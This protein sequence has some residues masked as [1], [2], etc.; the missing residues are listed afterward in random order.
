MRNA[1]TTAALA[2]LTFGV[3]ATAQTR[4]PPTDP[5][6][7]PSLER[8]MTGAER[9]AVAQGVS[10]ADRQFILDAA[11]A[12]LAEVEMG[13]L[14]LK[15]GEASRVKDFGQ[16]LVDDHGKANGELATLAKTLSVDVPT[17]TDAEHQKHLDLLAQKKGAEFDRVFATHMVEGHQKVIAKFK[18]EVAN[19]QNDTLKAF[20]QATLPTLDEHLRIAKGLAG[21]KTSQR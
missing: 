2:L 12:G 14:A 5:E 7:A 3:T 16:R 6:R 10:S 20:A 8:A 17:R 19:G 1:F 4:L 9:D 13:K 18:A 15:N 11:N 21:T